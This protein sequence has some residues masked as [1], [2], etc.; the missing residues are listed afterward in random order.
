VNG[1]SDL[2][3]IARETEAIVDAGGYRVG[4]A[5]PW[6]DLAGATAAARE[7]SH[8]H[9]PGESAPPAPP[10]LPAAAG[11]ATIEVTGETTLEAAR[12]LHRDA[13]APVAPVACLNFASAHHP[14]GG[15]RAGARAQEES[16]ARAS[17][18]AT[19]LEAVPEFYAF[20]RDQRH[21]I[22]SDRVICSP[23]VPVFRD[24]GGTLLDEPYPVTFLTAAAPNAGALRDRSRSAQGDADGDGAEVAET[25]RR[26]ARQVLAV[27]AGH[28]HRRLVLGA[29][30]CGVFRN[31]PRT[32]AG[33]FADLLGSPGGAFARS[34]AHVTFAVYD[35]GPAA[36]TRA[37][38][39]RALVR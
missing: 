33:A 11:P 30:G 31:D 18:L 9:P 35:P 32:V 10:P 34:F 8:L 37:A 29:W 4:G 20:H 6:V 26:R 14:G 28:G 23:A 5:G 39:E 25:L 38:F 24:D 13:G 7:G 12:R 17:A 1:R 22:Y 16:L 3:R 27:A 15:W 36:P 19:C 2:R 21:P